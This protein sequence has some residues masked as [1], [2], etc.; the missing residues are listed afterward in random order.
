[1]PRSNNSNNSYSPKRT[2][3]KPYSSPPIKQQPYPYTPTVQSQ[4]IQQRSFFGNI[5][6]G[7]AFST[8]ATIARNMFSSRPD[9]IVV[10]TKN[11]EKEIIK[12][13][14]CTE[15]NKCLQFEKDGDK[16]LYNDCIKKLNDNIYSQCSERKRYL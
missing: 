14:D 10:E 12:I 8:G 1:M 9:P 5:V 7:F 4:P 3:F 16:F 11:A 2:T 13:I 15:F 6:D